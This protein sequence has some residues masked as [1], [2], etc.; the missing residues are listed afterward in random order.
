MVEK[1]LMSERENIFASIR[2]ALSVPAPRPGHAHSPAAD[3]DHPPILPTPADHRR[4]MPLVGA[5][6]EEQLALFKKNAADL[7]ADF[8]SVK[9]V[10]TL[11]AELKQL[12]VAE[13]W[14]R[15]AAHHGELTDTAC[16]ALGIA[17]LFTHAAFD[18]QELGH[19]DAGITECDALIAQTGSVV[20]TSRSAGGRSLSVLPPHHVVLARRSQLVPDLPAAFAVLKSKYRSNYPSMLSIITGP[21][22]TGDIERILVLGAHGPKKLT[23]F[24]CEE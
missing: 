19:C 11:G 20:L 10:E 5:S 18:H 22:R 7:R 16:K 2:E 15:V 4:V 9:N 24:Y 1:S 23:I 17:P 3:K 13:G 8:R 14:K 12:G 21:S 6:A